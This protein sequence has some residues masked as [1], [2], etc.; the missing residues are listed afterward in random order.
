[1]SWDWRSRARPKRRRRAG[2]APLGGRSRFGSSWWGGAWV[3]ALEQRARLDPNR[4]PRGRSYARSGA[5][6]ELSIGPGEATALVQGSRAKPYQVR[7]RVREFTHREW[8]QLL[9]TIAARAAHAAALLDGVLDPEIVPE[10][11]A[12]GISLLPAAGELGPNCSCPDWAEPCKH[13]AAVCYL[14]ADRMDQDPFTILL[15]RGRERPQ[16]LAGVRLIRSQGEPAGQPGAGE[17]AGA[18]D[19]GVEARLAFARSGEPLALPPIPS[20]PEQPGRPAGVLLGE[21]DS[22]ALAADGLAELAAD[23][24]RRAWALSWGTGDGGLELAA[25]D[26]LARRAADHI[27]RP[28][29]DAL[30][31]RAG[32]APTTLMRLALAWRASGP[33]GLDVLLG[34]P[35]S[36]P[37][38]T[39]AAAAAAMERRVGA[40]SVHGERVTN[41]AAG[42]Q[43]RYGWDGLWY[44]LLHRGGRWELHESPAPDPDALLRSALSV[45]QVQ[46][47]GRP[48]RAS[49]PGGGHTGHRQRE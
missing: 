1:M 25:E 12:R 6:G 14:V 10:L 26:D 44:L 15:L 11:A 35:W 28:D 5:V 41:Q 36:P 20:P 39:M 32:M 48:S 49:S 40:S 13:A 7:L 17:A 42:L 22:A 29:F 31:R 47:A 4:L 33:T 8:Q 38:L 27:G 18:D 30:A 46:P 43:L 34:R 45:R 3:E 19:P 2:A 21:G 16:V 37:K 23:A 9:A 24:A